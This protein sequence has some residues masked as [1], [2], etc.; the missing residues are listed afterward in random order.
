MDM[1]VGLTMGGTFVSCRLDELDERCRCID[2]VMESVRALLVSRISW[3]LES[4]MAVRLE[5][6]DSPVLFGSKLFSVFWLSRAFRK[7]EMLSSSVANDPELVTPPASA[8]RPEPGWAEEERLCF[9]LLT[10]SSSPLLCPPNDGRPRRC[11]K[12]LL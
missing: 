10:W 6:T 4:C 9:P 5:A 7:S 12:L 11:V 8:R 2:D 1:E 3:N